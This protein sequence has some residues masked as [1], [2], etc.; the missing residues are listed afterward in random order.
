MIM[1]IETTL[2]DVII[3]AADISKWEKNVAQAAKRRAGK[4]VDHER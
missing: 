4:Q 1:N 2:S 3:G